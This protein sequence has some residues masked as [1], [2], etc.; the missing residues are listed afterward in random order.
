MVIGISRIGIV[1]IVGCNDVERHTP[2]QIFVDVRLKTAFQENHLDQISS[3]IDYEKVA[4][5]IIRIAVN[6][7][8]FLIETVAKAIVDGLLLSF[9]AV[10]EVWVK[11]EKPHALS[12]SESCYA[13][14]EQKRPK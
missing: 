4:D 2:Q 11:V 6:G 10:D 7:K 3:T 1:C 8:F 12:V 14:C 13:E 5:T 9:G